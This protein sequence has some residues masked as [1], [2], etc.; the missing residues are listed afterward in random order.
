[1]LRFCTVLIDHLLRNNEYES[2]IISGLT[3]LGTK[4]DKAWFDAED[5]IPKYSAV[6]KLARLMVVQE[7][8]EQQQEQICRYQNQ[9]IPEAVARRQ[10]SNNHNWVKRSVSRLMIIA[11]GNDDPTP[12]QWIYQTPFVQIQ[13]PIYPARRREDPVDPG[14]GVIPGDQVSDVPV[15]GAWST[16]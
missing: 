1:M 2:A 10:A 4:D 13:D 12:I 11:H 7:A 14:R 8:Y 9:N 6:I 5:Y 3:V 16:G 15:T